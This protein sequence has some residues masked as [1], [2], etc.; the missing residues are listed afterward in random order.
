MLRAMY[1]S[2]SDVEIYASLYIY[3]FKEKIHSVIIVT[4]K[5]GVLNSIDNAQRTHTQ[6]RIH[7]DM[8][9]AYTY[10]YVAEICI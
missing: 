10:L 5:V 6:T 8:T 9:I 2:F 4:H 1:L 7:M 3:D